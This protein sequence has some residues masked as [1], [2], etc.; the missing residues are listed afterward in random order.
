MYPTLE[1]SGCLSFTFW[2]ALNN[3]W[4]TESEYMSNGFV[5]FNGTNYYCFSN[6][7][8]IFYLDNMVVTKGVCPSASYNKSVE[9]FIGSSIFYLDNVVV[10]KGVCPSASYNKSFETFGFLG[11]TFTTLLGGSNSAEILCD[12]NGNGP[13]GSVVG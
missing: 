4:Q 7:S 6:G 12:T 13:P 3:E 9:I 1:G 11:W 10:T 2:H 8:S 5:I